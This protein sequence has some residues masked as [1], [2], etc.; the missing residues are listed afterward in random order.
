MRRRRGAGAG[1]GHRDRVGQSLRRHRRGRVVAPMNLCR[2]DLRR[3]DGP[4]VG[5]CSGETGIDLGP[6]TR[7]LVSFEP[8]RRIPATAASAPAVGAI[9]DPATNGIPSNPTKGVM[10]HLL[11]EA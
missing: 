6:R 7:C 9:P 3:V 8:E 10:E 4:V 11:T 1:L 5:M 2:D